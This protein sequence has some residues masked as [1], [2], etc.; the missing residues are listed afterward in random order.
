VVL[1]LEVECWVLTK[2]EL[3]PGLIDKMPFDTIVKLVQEE[4]SGEWKYSNL[5]YS[6]LP[7]EFGKPNY[8]L[9]LKSTGIR[10]PKV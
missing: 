5:I 6:F 10:V 7:E 4:T 2:G 9:L 1:S 3:E 8:N